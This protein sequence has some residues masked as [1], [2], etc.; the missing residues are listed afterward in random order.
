VL[1]TATPASVA[2]AVREAFPQEDFVIDT[3][4]DA[5]TVVA[6]VGVPSERDCMVMI[7]T[8][9]GKTRRIGFDRIQLEP[10]ETGC[11]TELYTHPAR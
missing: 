7:R 6:A 4:T 1:R 8:P 9:G 2:G 3:T 10:G 11:R 5:G